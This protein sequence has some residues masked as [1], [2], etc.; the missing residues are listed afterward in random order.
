MTV[1]TERYEAQLRSLMVASQA[2]DA[3]AYRTLLRDV[4]QR[5]TGYFRQRAG[6]PSA[7]ED[8]VQ[9]TLMAIHVKRDTYDPGQPLTAWI[10]AI[11]RYKLVDFYRAHRRRASLPLDDEAQF[12]AAADPAQGAAMARLD[13]DRAMAEL[14]APQAEALRLTKVEGL[15]VEEAAARSGRGVSAIKVNVH[16]GLKALRDRFAGREASS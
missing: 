6:D 11:A 13:L 5:L 15:S 12:L 3:A 2:G 14:S 1:V 8:L 16:R 10:Y 9:E 7:V 4:Q